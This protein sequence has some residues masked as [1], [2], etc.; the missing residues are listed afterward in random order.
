MNNAQ[1][2]YKQDGNIRPWWTPFSIWIQSIVPCLIWTVASWPAYRFL[3]RQ[4]RWSRV[5][6][7]WKIFQFFVI[8]L[9]KG[10]SVVNEVEAVFCFCYC[11]FWNSLV[12]LWQC[13]LVIW[14]LV[15]LFFVNPAWTF[16]NS[17]FMYCWSLFW[18]IL[19]II[20]L[21]YEMSAIVQ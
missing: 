14:S 10:F 16:G 20:L 3:R 17:K 21:P 11:F 2:L 7:S 8:H 18:R 6:I 4:I 19:S 5:P 1:K 15:P 12:F 9:V 13:M